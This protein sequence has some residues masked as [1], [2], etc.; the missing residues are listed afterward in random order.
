MDDSAEDQPAKRKRKKNHKVP[1]KP[2]VL[3]KTAEREKRLEMIADCII[4]GII[5]PTKIKQEIGSALSLQQICRDIEFLG[6]RWA[7]RSD[8]KIDIA[9]GKAIS[10]FEYL[11]SEA[12]T[13]WEKYKAIGEENPRFLDSAFKIV[14]QM[15]N[16]FGITQQNVTVNQTNVN[17]EHQQIVQQALANPQY[18]EWL[19]AQA[20]EQDA[21]PKVE[22]ISWLPSQDVIAEEAEIVNGPGSMEEDRNAGTVREDRIERSLANGETPATDLS[23]VGQGNATR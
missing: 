16:T 1:V 17:V 14:T 6:T 9:K 4:R 22:A 20:A 23:G 3:G 18:L 21:T 12:V 10:R 2:S 19:E 13:A 8:E 5:T 7:E 11:Y 15:C